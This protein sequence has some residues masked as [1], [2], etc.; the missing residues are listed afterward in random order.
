MGLY[1]SW[2]LPWAVD[3]LMSRPWIRDERRP[4]LER[5]TGRVL[6]IGFG[7]GTS[8]AAYPPGAVDRV[9][10]LEPNRA[11]WP[12]ARR[13]AGQA[14]IAIDL[15]D[16]RAE[17]M[18]FDDASFDTVVSGF[19]LCSIRPLDEALRE[20][21]R[22]LAPGGRFVFV[23]HGRSADPRI[24]RWQRRLNVVH[25]LYADGCRL[26]LPVDDALRDAGFDLEALDRFVPA[27]GL[28][29]FVEMYRGSARPTWVA[30]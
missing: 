23:E 16:A 12:R 6:E 24:A 1:R 27:H 14:G 10:A 19:T 2:L 9:T 28:R 20:V 18:P 15:V 3:R 26:D 7:T 11:M 25:A 21:R 13:R 17:A 22:V 8:L 4:A 29:P 30:S 5:V